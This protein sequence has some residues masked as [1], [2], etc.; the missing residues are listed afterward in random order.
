M[1]EVARTESFQKQ[2][3]F[4]VLVKKARIKWEITGEKEKAQLIWNSQI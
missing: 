4:S 2:R 1:E 3:F